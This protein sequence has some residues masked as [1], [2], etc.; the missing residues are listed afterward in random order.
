M[1]ARLIGARR[2]AGGLQQ[3]ALVW[4]FP[5]GTVQW[6]GT[7]S[8]SYGAGHPTQHMLP[9]CTCCA[10][11]QYPT[12]SHQAWWPST[13]SFSLMRRGRFLPSQ[14]ARDMSIYA[15]CHLWGCFVAFLPPCDAAWYSSLPPTPFMPVQPFP[16]ML[17]ANIPQL[18]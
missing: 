1:E 3:A 14:R 16:F 11:V 13:S 18:S 4:G 7:V 10:S 2:A 8:C 15:H 9:G 12:S 5:T 17:A 6:G